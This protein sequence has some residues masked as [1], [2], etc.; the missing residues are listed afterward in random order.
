MLCTVITSTSHNH[1]DDTLS[2]KAVLGVPVQGYC[3]NI[4]ISKFVETKINK[5]ITLTIYSLITI[6]NHIPSL[7]SCEKLVLVLPSQ[8]RKNRSRCMNPSVP[9]CVIHELCA[10]AAVY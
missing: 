10:T 4:V 9:Q 8:Q 7:S 5:L 3:N 1:T 6:V 2:Y